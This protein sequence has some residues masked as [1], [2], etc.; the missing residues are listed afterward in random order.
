MYLLAKTKRKCI[1]LGPR[2]NQRAGT[3]HLFRTSNR[4]KVAWL[5]REPKM[6]TKAHI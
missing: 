1:Y 6:S 3:W 5:N 4:R 2:G